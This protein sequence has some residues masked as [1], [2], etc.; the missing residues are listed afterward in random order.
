[1]MVSL[2]QLASIIYLAFTDDL[3]PS[4][5]SFI[6]TSPSQFP[7]LLINPWLVNPDTWQTWLGSS[8]LRPSKSH[9]SSNK[10]TLI[11]LTRFTIE[12]GLVTTVA[13]LLELILGI[14]YKQH[15]YHVALF[16]AISKLYAN[17]LLASLNF[18][19]ILRTQSDPKQTAI[20]WDDATSNARSVQPGY[21]SSHVVQILAP[22]ESDVDVAVDLNKTD[23]R[24]NSSI[25]D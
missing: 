4:N 5:E 2:L 6:P 3:F 10:S 24:E 19:L 13:A 23:P 12:T 15:M 14:V 11:K 7:Q 25:E 9:F 21:Q 17:C 1:M 18:R 22:V 16:Y 20:L 8:V